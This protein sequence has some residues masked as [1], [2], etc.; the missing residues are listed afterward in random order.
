VAL[1]LRVMSFQSQALGAQSAKTFGAE[2]GSIGRSQGNDWVLPDPE[3]FVSGLH[4]EISCRNGVYYLRDVSTNGTFVNGSPQPIGNGREQPLE[5]GDRLQIGEYDISVSLVDQADQSLVT[6][7]TGFDLGAGRTPSWTGGATGPSGPG[8][9]GSAGSTGPTGQRGS[10]GFGAAG[11]GQSSSI[12]PLDI[13]ADHSQPAARPAADPGV[14][15]DHSPALDEF[16]Q[17]P[18]LT[19]PPSAVPRGA[20][21]EGPGRAPTGIPEDWD[22]TGYAQ[23]Y[24]A[25]AS[26]D[27][28]DF[29]PA[30][31]QAGPPAAARMPPAPHASRMP[32]APPASHA[33]PPPA[34]PAP[35]PSAAQPTS[36][37]MSGEQADAIIA[38]LTA[39]GMD[40]A[41]ARAAASSPELV[42]SLG[43]LLGVAVQGMLDVLKARSEIKSQFRVPVTMMRP[44][45]NNPLKFSANAMQAL[46]NLLV[47]QNQAYL[48]PVEAFAEG[49]HD[50]KAHQMA[51]IAGMRAAFDS[52]IERFD[53][54]ELVERF[55][56]RLKRGALL[57]LPGKGRYWDLYRD[58]YEEWTQDADVNFQRLFGEKF[59]QAYEE[60]MRRLTAV[61][62]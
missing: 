7:P 59:S 35:P 53:P 20:H 26:L 30:Q 31:P 45:E 44:V 62:R 47:A 23:P 21:A 29:A 13:F 55:E 40:P 28:D 52:M 17:P 19:P 36:M 9:M 11:P 15:S 27:A 58:L 2:G 49:F 34:S 37:P 56:K 60:Q 43:A 14:I 50:V 33:P 12:D 48:G 3:K 54:D 8:G 57:S 4:A 16:Y 10:H 46:H 42:G 51:M 61:R 24:D 5:E 25:P 41:S 22:K 39:A 18:P 6:G 38:M 32:S 1:T